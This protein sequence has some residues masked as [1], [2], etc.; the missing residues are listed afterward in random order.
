MYF[1][2]KTKGTNY[3]KQFDYPLFVAVIMLSAIGLIAL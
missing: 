1:V 2:E 3:L